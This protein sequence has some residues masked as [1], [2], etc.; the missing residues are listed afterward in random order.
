MLC[1]AIALFYKLQPQMTIVLTALSKNYKLHKGRIYSIAELLYC[2]DLYYTGATLKVHPFYSINSYVVPG[3]LT[4]WL[5]P[6]TKMRKCDTTVPPSHCSSQFDAYCKLLA[7]SITAWWF[8]V[9]LRKPK[10][11][12]TASEFSW[13]LKIDLRNTV[14]HQDIMQINAFYWVVLQTDCAVRRKI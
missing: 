8:Y 6:W 2:I 7:C 9:L 4:F 12:P 3:V 13:L 14:T 11:R 1:A 5:K 10:M